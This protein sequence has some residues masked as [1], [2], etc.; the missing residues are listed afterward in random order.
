MGLFEWVA[1]GAVMAAGAVLIGFPAGIAVG[2]A[3]RDRI[4]RARRALV[5]QER[6]RAKPDAAAAALVR[7][8]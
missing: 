2:Y 8:G 7:G 3:W 5:E 1:V 6:R 4:S